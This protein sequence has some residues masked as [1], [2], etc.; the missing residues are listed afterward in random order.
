MWH[1]N[2]EYNS[3]NTSEVK[4]AKK[5]MLAKPN[6]PDTIKAFVLALGLDHALACY[7]NLSASSKGGEF[8]KIKFQNILIRFIKNN[9]LK[10][11]DVSRMRYLGYYTLLEIYLNEKNTIGGPSL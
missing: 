7:S 4:A 3:S 10:T 6:D 11:G 2:P 9:E 8:D 5:A 1:K